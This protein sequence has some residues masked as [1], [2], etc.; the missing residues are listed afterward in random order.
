MFLEIAGEQKN[1]VEPLPTRAAALRKNAVSLPPDTFDLQAAD[2]SRYRYARERAWR[3]LMQARAEPDGS[4]LLRYVNGD[5]QGPVLPTLDCYLL[6][7]AAN[8]PTRRYRSTS[9]AV[10]VVAQGQGS[11]QV[12]GVRIEWKQRDVFSLPHWNWISHTA[13]DDA[14]IF[15][16]TDRELLESLGYLRE[17]EQV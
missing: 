8:Q 17:E 15:M 3:A 14:V 13:S 6:A 16:M 2:P 12:G 7:C 1:I 11:S 5:S 9:N 4:R 10:C